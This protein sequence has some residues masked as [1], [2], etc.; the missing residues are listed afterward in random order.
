MLSPLHEDAK[1]HGGGGEREDHADEHGGAKARRRIEEEEE[2]RSGANRAEHLARAPHE[3]RPPD[4]PEPRGRELEADHEEEHRHAHFREHL[5]VVRV[6]DQTEP[7]RP[8][9]DTREHE[10]DGGGDAESPAREEHEERRRQ[11]DD[12]ILEE[13]GF[14]HG[15]RVHNRSRTRD[16]LVC[17]TP[18]RCTM[19]LGPRGRPKPRRP[20]H[21]PRNR[22][23]LAPQPGN[24]L[25]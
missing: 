13:R 14:L 6:A 10:P 4:L 11:R 3:E 18:R 20:A 12:E 2:A 8:D 25:P 22:C 19:T 7:A 16:V 15:S 24:P 1:H 5:D 17:R 21:A 9:Q 23:R